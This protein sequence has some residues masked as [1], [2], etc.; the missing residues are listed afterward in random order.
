MS[1]RER[2]SMTK[3]NKRKSEV[4]EGNLQY[5][6][7]THSV[8]TVGGGVAPVSPLCAASLLCPNAATS[9]SSCLWKQYTM[10]PSLCFSHPLNLEE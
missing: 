9:Q 10:S 5:H 1:Q 2:E 7:A 3:G 4:C 6:G 8:F